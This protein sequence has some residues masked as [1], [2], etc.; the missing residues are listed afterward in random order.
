MIQSW[1][2]GT[3]YSGN[4][5]NLGI[6][7][8]IFKRIQYYEEPL[9]YVRVNHH[10]LVD[11]KPNYNIIECNEDCSDNATIIIV[12]PENDIQYEYI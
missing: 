4:L 9:N 11:T 7:C 1:G 2:G 12:G 10:Y 8:F 3:Q 5:H 6:S